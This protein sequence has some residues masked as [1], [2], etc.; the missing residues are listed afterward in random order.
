MGARRMQNRRL[1]PAR[2]RVTIPRHAGFTMVELIVVMILIG[3][4][5]A[6][7]GAKFFNPTGFDTA[8]YAEQMRAMTRYAQ[9]LA[10]AQHRNVFVVGSLDGIALCYTNS[11][12]CPAAQ[13]VLA[14]GGSNSGSGATR[15]FCVSG[16]AY[17]ANWYCEGRPAGVTMAPSSGSISP[18]YFNALGKPFLPPDLPPGDAPSLN[19]SFAT[20][21][22]NFSGDGVSIPVTIYQETGY[23]N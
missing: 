15:A 2:R 13:V 7:G 6:I 12:P 17:A 19:S 20:T 4:L 1:V 22:F 9:K 3:I 8:G 18:F 11:L 14:P 16:G 21:S 23:V 10:I 5:A